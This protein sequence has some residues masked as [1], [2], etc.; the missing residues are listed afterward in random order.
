M[1]LLQGPEPHVA[2]FKA[3]EDG[4]A[5][6]QLLPQITR[7]AKLTVPSIPSQE[8]KDLLD[9]DDRWRLLQRC[10]TDDAL[11]TDVRAGGTITLLF[12][13]STERLCHLTPD[14][15]SSVTSTPPWS[16]AAAPS[17]CLHGLPNSFGNLWN[18]PN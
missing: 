16:W 7:G 8:P 13:T 11:P 12:G 6:Q 15:S 5:V 14:T 9:D 17:C 18:S 10:L 2:A 3:D 1:P 4:P